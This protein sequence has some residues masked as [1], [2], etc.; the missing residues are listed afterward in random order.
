MSILFLNEL[1]VTCWLINLYWFDS[2]YSIILLT[3]WFQ[4]ILVGILGNMCCVAEV[5]AMF[6]DNDKLCALLLQLMAC[7]DAQTL[8]Q[9]TRCFNSFTWDLLKSD[10]T[11]TTER[12]WFEEQIVSGQFPSQLAFILS[13][14]LCGKR[15]T[16]CLFSFLS[17]F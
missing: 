10:S 5:R 2:N 1:G 16:M 15:V 6:S 14:S 12:H 11:L 4:E 13:S 3:C 17:A 7:P 9:L 8:I